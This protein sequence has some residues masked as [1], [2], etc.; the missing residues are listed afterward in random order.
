M[1]KKFFA[2]SIEAFPHDYRKA[3]TLWK[4]ANSISFTCAISTTVYG[5]A[6][7]FLGSSWLVLTVFSAVSFGFLVLWRP[8][9]LPVQ[10][11]QPA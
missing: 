8:R 11:D 3:L 2:E 9:P 1:R 10:G 5:V 4:R 7:K 6:L